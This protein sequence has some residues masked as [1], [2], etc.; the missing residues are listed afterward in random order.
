MGAK[1]SFEKRPNNFKT[2]PKN[3]IKKCYDLNLTKKIAGNVCQN[4]NLA[5]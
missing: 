5:I 2:I 1:N 3:D 4:L